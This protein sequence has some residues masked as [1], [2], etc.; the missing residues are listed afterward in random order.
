M[1]NIL[2]ATDFSDN[3]K[4]ALNVAIKLA[5]KQKATLHLFHSVH[6]QTYYVNVSMS[7]IGDM[8]EQLRSEADK[9]MKK[10]EK[11]VP[12]GIKLK[13]YVGYNYLGDELKGYITKE[14]IDI[15][16]I[17]AGG[18][19][20]LQYSLLGS[21]SNWI[22]DNISCPALIIPPGYEFKN[23][24]KMVYA[25]D[26]TGDEFTSLVKYAE[27]AKLFD[28]DLT[29]LHI[30]T[31]GEESER[32]ITKLMAKVRLQADYPKV[33]IHQKNYSDAFEG[34]NEYI[35]EVHPDVF[36]MAIHDRSFFEK[37]SHVSL[38]KKMVHLSKIPLLILHKERASKR[39]GVIV[40]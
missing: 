27:F 22:M 32:E 11:L 14:K 28:A 7:F 13:T 8:T 25:S 5:K 37:L 6:I 40:I 16:V 23:F 19:S 10:L 9:E 15:V 20:K 1:E 34:I 21:S 24:S 39:A 26:L 4:C 12:G 18:G 31:D 29:V 30:K 2:I 35:T 33:H 17:G 3:A 38:T 36:A